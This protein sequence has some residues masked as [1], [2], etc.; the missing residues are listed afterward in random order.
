RRPEQTAVAGRVAPHLGGAQE[1][2]GVHHPFGRRGGISGRSHHGDDGAAGEGEDVRASAA[3]AAARYH[4]A[5]EDAAI[6]RADCAHLV[7]P[8]RGGAP[9]ASAGGGDEIMSVQTISTRSQ[10]ASKM[11]ARTRDRLLNIISPLVLL[12]LWELCARFGFI[13]T[14]FF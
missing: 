5:A 12:V 7:E 1:D 6:R 9:C 3:R 13:D 2:R 4:G 11:S 8:A 14:R 10:A